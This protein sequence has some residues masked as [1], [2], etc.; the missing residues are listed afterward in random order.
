M[1]SISGMSDYLA[2]C[3]LMVHFNIITDSII[4]NNITA[5]EIEDDVTCTSIELITPTPIASTVHVT[6]I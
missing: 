5:I 1:L 4:Y 6:G 2:V 3:S